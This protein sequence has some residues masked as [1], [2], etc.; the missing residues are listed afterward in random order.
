[1]TT[2]T[3]PA[4][5]APY[6]TPAPLRL[7]LYV[8]F[9]LCGVV[10]VVAGTISLLDQ[11]A[12][13]T[14]TEVTSYSG[15]DRLLVDDASDVT[16]TSAPAGGR[17]VVRERVTEGLQS[18]DRDV[19]QDGGTLTLSSSCGFL[20]AGDNCNVDYEIAVPPGTAVRVDA[21]GGDVRAEDLRSSVPVELESSAGDVSLTDVTAPELLL[22][23]SAGD[24]DATDV[25]ADRVIAESSAGDVSLSL[26]SAP[27]RV[28]ADSS[29][30]DVE[31]VVPDEVYS[32]DASSSAGDVDT[33]RV[34]N[35]PSS[36]RAIR[37]RSSA[38]DVT[39]EARR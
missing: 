15:I 25:R 27:T 20:F 32:V 18:P 36:D 35:D 22:S 37:A 39:V 29:A 6:R 2:Q 8:L 24:V 13:E 38:G 9:G 31:I 1:M 17:L 19:S 11:A 4:T 33:R 14:T 5:P 21:S 16:L 30:G 34:R 28:D 12:R 26:R 3:Q 10:M 23:S 7:A